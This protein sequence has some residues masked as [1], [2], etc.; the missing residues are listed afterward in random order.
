[1]RER[2]KENMAK[3]A[4]MRKNARVGRA[5]EIFSKYTAGHSTGYTGTACPSKKSLA[6]GKSHLVQQP[7][8]MLT[9]IID[10]RMKEKLAKEKTASD[11]LANTGRD[12]EKSTGKKT[13]QSSKTFKLEKTEE[14]PSQISDKKSV[15]CD[16][17]PDDSTRVRSRKSLVALS[18][19]P[20]KD[21]STGN[22][23][24]A[25]PTKSDSHAFIAGRDIKAATGTVHGK[26]TTRY[27]KGYIPAGSEGSLGKHMREN[28]ADILGGDEFVPPYKRTK[29]APVPK[30]A[31]DLMLEALFDMEN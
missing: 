6:A 29:G 14:I 2:R 5:R 25:S 16:E 18:A 20:A 10:I 31:N 4:L 9:I 7:Q 24:E 3:T 21:V 13:A 26:T 28:M 19:S 1:M 11:T 12:N 8:L 30:T 17:S 22:K 27:Y 15:I 23:F